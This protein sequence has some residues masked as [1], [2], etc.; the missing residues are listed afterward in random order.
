MK[1]LRFLG[2]A[3]LACSMM[4]VSCKKDNPKPDNNTTDNP[5]GGGG[6]T[7]PDGG[8]TV[9]FDGTAWDAAG[10]NGL[11]FEDYAAWQVYAFKVE[12][13]TA[14]D[15]PYA[16]VCMKNTTA[17]QTG[18]I[19]PQSLEI[20]NDNFYYIEY[21]K[22][23]RLQS[24]SSTGVTYYG[25]WWFKTGTVTV[26]AFDATSLKLKANVNVT[27][28]DAYQALVGETATGIEAASTAP[29]IVDMNNIQLQV[30]STKG[31]LKRHA[32]S[33]LTV[34]R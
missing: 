9:T 13:A 6:Q 5:G 7:T 33:K 1:A 27:M 22:D 24:T 26:S 28:F 12:N 25:D 4:F 31:T 17:P 8:A 20:D 23:R 10:L 19:D 2:I 30:P 14:T 15:F 34:A 16:L 11:Y 3:L 32:D 29:M 21:Y 18:T